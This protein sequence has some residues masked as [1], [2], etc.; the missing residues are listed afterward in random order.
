M[1][2]KKQNARVH[3][4][5]KDCTVYEHDHPTNRLSYA[6]T[7]IDGRYPTEKR[8]VN[9]ECEGM[10]FVISGSGTIH[11]EKGDF[12]IN[13]GDSYSLKQGEKYYIKGDKLLLSLINAPKW[14]PEQQKVV[15]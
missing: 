12:Q 1:L 15:D 4:G 6:T 5:S 3:E 9:T 2:I 13:E 10:F 14:T 11:S 8:V 7:S